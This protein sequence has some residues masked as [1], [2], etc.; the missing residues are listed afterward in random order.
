MNKN[1]ARRGIGAWR[2]ELVIKYKMLFTIC[3][4]I[5]IITVDLE[6]CHH[7][8]KKVIVVMALLSY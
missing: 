6:T 2:F 1:A 8:M 5:Y 4:G 3:T 7:V